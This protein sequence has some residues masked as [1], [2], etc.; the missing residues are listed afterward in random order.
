MF[1]FKLYFHGALPRAAKCPF[2]CPPTWSY[3]A[4]LRHQKPKAAS[5]YSL[6]TGTGEG[7][8]RRGFGSGRRVRPARR[9]PGVSPSP[10]PADA[11][12]GGTSG[13]Q[14]GSA[15]GRAGTGREAPP[16]VTS[17]PKQLFPPHYNRLLARGSVWSELRDV[18]STIKQ[19]EET[20]PPE[21]A[22]D[23]RSRTSDRRP[24]LG[25]SLTSTAAR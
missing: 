9:S 25:D 3:L 18:N 24:R 6:P 15:R 16:Y 20:S 2:P 17:K 8:A 13:L 21:E 23:R 22:S 4:P 5:Q 10:L 7:R 14:V 11:L 1:Y 12:Q 19:K